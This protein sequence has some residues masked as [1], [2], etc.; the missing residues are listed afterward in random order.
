MTESSLVSGP[1][2]IPLLW[3]TPQFAFR[4]YPLLIGHTIP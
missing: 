1:E 4:R 2:R 3:R